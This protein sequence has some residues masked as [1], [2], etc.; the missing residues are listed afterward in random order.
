MG[1]LLEQI[2]ILEGEK[3]IATVIKAIRTGAKDVDEFV[4]TLK[5]AQASLWMM[6]QMQT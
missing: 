3:E 4:N 1:L 5:K 6:F 2:E